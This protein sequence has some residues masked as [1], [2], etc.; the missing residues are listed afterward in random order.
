[1]TFLIYRRTAHIIKLAL[2]FH[3]AWPGVGHVVKAGSGYRFVPTPVLPV[4]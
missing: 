4:L 3:M 2:I 1:M